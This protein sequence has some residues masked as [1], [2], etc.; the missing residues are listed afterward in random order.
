MRRLAG[1]SLISILSLSLVALAQPAS[2]YELVL[3][4]INAAETAL[5]SAKDRL[6]AWCQPGHPH[7][8]PEV[9]SDTTVTTAPTT[10]VTV[11]PVTTTT[12]PPVVTTTTTVPTTG[13]YGAGVAGASLPIPA[14]AIPVTSLTLAKA[15]SDNPAGS[16][17]ALA[18]G[19]YRIGDI[20]N[21]AGNGYYGTPEDHAAVILDG[22]TT[23][24]NGKPTSGKMRPFTLADGNV[25]ANLTIRRYRGDDTKGSAPLWGP[26]SGV[27]VRNVE[28][29]E[30]QFVGLRFAGSTWDVSY[31]TSR[32]NGQYCY[33]GS[34]TGHRLSHF[35]AQECGNAGLLVP[36][37]SQND[38]GGSKFVQ[39]SNLTVEDGEIADM[40][41]NGLW[42]DIGNRDVII[43]R[44]WVHGVEQHG[45][46]VEA[47]YG[48]AL[49]EDNLVENSAFETLSTPY[50]RACIFFAVTQDVTIRNNTVDTCKNGI[51]GYQWN[52]PQYQGTISG[53]VQ[54]T[55]VR[56]ARVHNNTIRNVT[57]HWAGIASLTALAGCD[58]N[59]PCADNRF[60]DNIYEGMPSFWWDDST[61][62][63]AY[64]TAEGHS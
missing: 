47:S 32:H 2:E 56:R 62:N 40:Q 46:D 21:K 44:L 64:W 15:I 59:N 38:R 11:A 54:A 12:P 6:E 1:I 25:V 23:Y 58:A 28:L 26:A 51:M 34:G 61:R 43:R 50:R 41:D 16:I 35:I 48:P 49:I 36:R 22:E 37:Y 17:F 27:I 57:G 39:T 19:I 10:T 53:T 60:Y 7:Y 20:P 18:P 13:I 29:Y 63:L 5:S 42:V 24:V 45:I 52:H 9:C 14:G 4:D 33:G 3:A 8:D 55:P 31:I 30:N